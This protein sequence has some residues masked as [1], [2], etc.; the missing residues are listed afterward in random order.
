MRQLYT[1]CV[2]N[3]IVYAH[4]CTCVYTMWL[5]THTVYSCVCNHIVY[6]HT[7]TCVYTMWLHTHTYILQ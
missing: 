7:C 3:P 5:H 1:V 6:A 2:C 4:T